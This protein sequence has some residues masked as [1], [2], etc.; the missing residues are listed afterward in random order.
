MLNIIG[1]GEISL[2][3]M[4][5]EIYRCGSNRVYVHHD[6][7][8]CLFE[9]NEIFPELVAISEIPVESSPAMMIHDVW[10]GE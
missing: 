5:L 9:E 6:S 8:E 4:R 3:E 2:D 1:I 7:H 10:S